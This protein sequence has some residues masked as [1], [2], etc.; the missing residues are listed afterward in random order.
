M[1]AKI[2]DDR[3]LALARDVLDI[4]A[5]A[6]RALADQLDGEFVAAVGLLLE[7]RGRVVVSGIGKSGHIARKIAATLASTGTPAFFVHPAEASHGDL[8]M[9]TKDD[10]FVAISNSGESEEL[11]AILPLIKRLGAKLIAMT[12]RPAS[13]LATLSDVH[14][15]AGVAKEAC[16]LNLAPT[17]STTAALALG[18]A[19]AVAVLDARGFGSDDF[20][21]SHPGGALGRRL[22]TYVRDVM[23]TGDEVPA[24][25]LGATLSDALF[26]ITAKRMGM[27]AVV[28]DAGRVAG[29]FTDGDLRRVLERDGDF[30]RLPI[31]DVMTR[32]PRTI[33]PDHL[34]VE[35]VELMERHRIN[36]MLVVD[37]HGALIGALNMHDLFSKKVI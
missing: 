15:N 31:V 7:C 30:R 34:A 36:Q 33:A 27:T 28:D 25:P 11:V 23:R 16:P 2:N 35:A 18:D 10:V 20:A 5:S 37:E 1:I 9:V 22:L 24:V 14:L 6:V 3:A 4:E 8:G 26:Q 17:A 19:L 29:I 12:G 21:R 13:S 32:N